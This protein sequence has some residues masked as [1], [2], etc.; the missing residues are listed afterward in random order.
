MQT[1]ERSRVE[2][3]LDDSAAL[4]KL[5]VSVRAWKIKLATAVCFAIAV[6]VRIAFDLPLIGHVYASYI[7]IIAPI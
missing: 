4:H 3:T 6:P 1:T 7:S 2:V 5:T